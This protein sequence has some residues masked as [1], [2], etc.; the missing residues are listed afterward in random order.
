[1]AETNDEVNRVLSAQQRAQQQEIIHALG[2]QPTI[3]IDDERQRREQFLVDYLRHTGGRALVLGISGGVDSLLAGLIAQHA[4][5][6]ARAQGL[7]A[8]FYALRLLYGQPAAADSA[9]ASVRLTAQA[10]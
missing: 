10:E 7:Q 9:I 2:V 1:M 8:S 5:Q 6:S 4:V 3:D